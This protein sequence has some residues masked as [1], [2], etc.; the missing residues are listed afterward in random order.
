MRRA[1]RT[2]ANHS[3]VVRALL[4]AGCSVQSLAMVGCGVP[5]LLVWSPTAGYVLVEVKDGDKAP[6]KRALTPDQVKFH[7]AWKGPI[8]VVETVAEALAA[9]G[10]VQRG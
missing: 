2:D 8:A 5:D 3:E 7:R 1:A 9:V 6:S 10:V 4:D